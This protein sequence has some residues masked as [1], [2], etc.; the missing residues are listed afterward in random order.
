MSTASYSATL[1]TKKYTST[2]NAKPSA[3][4]Q[5]FYDNSYNYVGIISFSGMNL[6]NK[7]I[8]GITLTVTSAKAGFGASHTKTVYLRKSNYQNATTEATGGGYTGDA[9]GTFTGSFYDNTTT[10]ELSGSL[11]TAMASYISAGNNTF[12]IYNPSPSASYEGYS[13]NYLQWTDV[14]ITVT[15]TEGVSV[16]TVS[17]SSADLDTSFLISTNRVNS[18]ATH[19]LLYVFGSESA[20]I[21]DNVGTGYTWTPPLSLAAQVPNATAGIC[22]IYC[23]TYIGG[24]YTGYSTCT[25]TL[26]VPSYVTP[27]LSFVTMEAN[28]DISRQFGCYVRTHSQL[29]VT[30]TAGGNRGSTISSYRAT[31][32]GTTYTTSSF[33]TNYLNTAGENTLTVTVTDSRGRT[34]SLTTTID[35]ADY[36]PPSLTRF[37]AERSNSDGSAAQTDG[38]NVRVNVAGSV[39]PVE[40]KN[41]FSCTVYYKLKS[42]ASWTSAGTIA[43]SGYTI[44]AVNQVLSQ[45]FAVLSSYDIKVRLQDYF[46]YVE[47]S[48]SIGTKQVI[49]DILSNGQG[50]AFGKIAETSGCVDFGW[51]LKLNTPLS[52]ANGGTGASSA[53]MALYNLGGVS[54]SGDSMTG[55]LSIINYLYPSLYL[56]PSYNGT[57]NRTVFEG[58]YV[59]ASSFAAWED[60]TG[61]NRRMLEVRTKGY[62]PSLDYAVLLRVA[63]AGV[64]SMFRVFHSGMESPVPVYC[65]GTGA[66]NASTARYYLG[67]NDA[68]NLTAGTIPA[69]RLPFKIA[70]GTV[71]VNSSSSVYID[72]SGTGFNSA[73]YVVIN[74]ATT[75]SNWTG[76]GGV[77]KVY[78][79]TKFGCYVTVGG[80][81]G[82]TRSAD[83]IAI[84]I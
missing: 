25:I 16:V 5:E 2:S 34:T 80:S 69:A 29:Y 19:S 70:Y 81:Y 60:D 67:A 39:S 72:Y 11:L 65:G 43:P 68:S 22:T 74:Y 49:M 41:T 47:Q 42:A 30:I 13:Q 45:T 53:S 1:R 62:S 82:T 4:C 7:V 59:G 20:S 58:S 52:V 55:N 54:R 23:Y 10:Y 75:D 76:T 33:T 84:G 9:L 61:N 36:S 14:T 6:A 63:D 46:S 21:A 51:P 18:S 71:S 56:L 44:N 3:A 50:I 37:T 73:P 66:T 8:S 78:N 35:V 79:K 48:V 40:N 28:S 17:K 31:I 77:I 26:T 38:S 57:T 32:N 27:S 12:T 64:W 24:I 83:Y 15:Y